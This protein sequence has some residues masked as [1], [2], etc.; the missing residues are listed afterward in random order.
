MGPAVQRS[1]GQVARRRVARRRRVTSLRRLAPAAGSCGTA[2]PGAATPARRGAVL[3]GQGAAQ[4]GGAE[5]ARLGGRTGGPPRSRQRTRSSR[6]SEARP[7]LRLTVPSGAERAPVLGGVGGEL[8]EGERQAL[9][10]GGAEGDVGQVEHEAGRRRRRSAAPGSGGRGRRG[11]PSASRWRSAGRGRWRARPAGRGRRRRRP[12]V[13]TARAAVW[14]AIARITPAC[15]SPG[16]SAR[17]AGA[18]GA[19]PRP[20]AR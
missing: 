4:Q 15:S 10:Q 7:A 17:P 1:S 19:P 12:V 3:V 2:G 20:C 11:S 16:G 9:R 6:P 5:A 8:V 14:L 18:P 13:D